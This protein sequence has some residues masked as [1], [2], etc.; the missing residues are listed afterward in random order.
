MVAVDLDVD[1]EVFD[2]FEF[3]PTAQMIS[4]ATRTTPMTAMAPTRQLLV[5]QRLWT[6]VG[7]GGVVVLG[8]AGVVV[9]GS[10]PGGGAGR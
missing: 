9:W 8:G 3:L 1:V 2:D 5:R 7:T 4:P 6:A 10:G